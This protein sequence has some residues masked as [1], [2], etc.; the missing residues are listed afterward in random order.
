MLSPIRPLLGAIG[1]KKYAIRASDAFRDHKI[2]GLKEDYEYKMIRLDSNLSKDKKSEK[3]LDFLMEKYG[4]LI[5]LPASCL[6]DEHR[7]NLGGGL[8]CFSFVS[9]RN[10]DGRRIK[11]KNKRCGNPVIKG[12]FFCKK[13]GGGNTYGL[14]NGKSMNPMLAAYKKAFDGSLGDLLSCFVNDKDM[15]DIRPELVS[16]RI[17]LNNYIKKLV[18]GKSINPNRFMK[19]INNIVEIEELSN[20]EKFVMIKNLSDSIH[21]IT[22]GD[23]IDRLTRVIETLSRVTERINKIQSKDDYIL[24]PEGLRIFL[25]AIVDIINDNIEDESAKRNIHEALMTISLKT[26]GD[27]NKYKKEDIIEADYQVE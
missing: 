24:T 15:T 9:L 6:P 13:H 8:R 19:E 26:G 21:T 5:A 4:Y 20:T 25:R 7:A 22:D 12:S 1:D 18:D 27:L 23:S 14:V 11:G 2:M 17:I 10:E 3:K 16:L